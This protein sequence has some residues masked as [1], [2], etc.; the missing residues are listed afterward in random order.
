MLKVEILAIETDN[1]GSTAIFPGFGL[2]GD[3]FPEPYLVT[4]GLHD[5]VATSRPAAG[6]A[7]PG[8]PV[9]R[10][11]RRRP[12]ARAAGAVPRARGGDRRGGR[13]QHCR[14]SPAPPCPPSSRY[15]STALRTIPPRETGGNLDVPQARAGATVFLPVDVPGA[16]LS[17]GDVALRAGRRRG[18]RHRDRDARPR[19]AA[20]RRAA[21]RPARLPPADARVRVGRAG[22]E[23]RPAAL[24]D[25]GPARSA[26]TA[27]T[28]TW[29]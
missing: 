19:H 2:L 22:L 14:P 11:D 27:R 28:P 29:T 12:V 17:L 16:L 1:F 25:D 26:P 20:R 10:R 9:H 6:R 8:R 4:W 5:G 24:R 13:R 3:L 18:L 23:G 15:A 21:G 7:H